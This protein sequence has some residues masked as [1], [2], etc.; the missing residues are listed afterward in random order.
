MF[1]CQHH[2]RFSF[3]SYAR[4]PSGRFRPLFGAPSRSRHPHRVHYVGEKDR[5]VTLS[6]RKKGGHRK[7]TPVGHKSGPE[8]ENPPRR[9][10]RFISESRT[11]SFVFSGGSVPFLTPKG[12]QPP[13]GWLEP[14]CCVRPTAPSRC[15]LPRR[16]SPGAS[17]QPTAKYHLQ[18]IVGIGR[19]RPTRNHTA[20]EG[21]A[22]EPLSH[23]P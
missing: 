20:R 10:D 1:F 9:T 6:S 18:P 5:F 15:G 22:K 17:G 21:P 11:Y 13:S 19:G 3:E 12:H 4:S 2:L 8:V 16:V 23:L 7:S 14:L